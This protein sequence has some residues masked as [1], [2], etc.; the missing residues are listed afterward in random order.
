MPK[1]PTVRYLK[2][3]RQQAVNMAVEDGFGVTETARRLSILAKT[4]PNWVTQYRL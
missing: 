2:E 4:L 1:T 3:L